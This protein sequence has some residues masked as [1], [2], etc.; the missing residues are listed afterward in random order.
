MDEDAAWSLLRSGASAQ[1]W[2]EAHLA[3]GQALSNREVVAATGIDSKEA[4][5][6]FRFLKQIGTAVKDPEGPDR[7]AGVRWIASDR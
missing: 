2:V 4:T 1:A 7:G 6:L 3:E 5:A